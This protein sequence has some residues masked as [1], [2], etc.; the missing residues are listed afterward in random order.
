MSSST[1][2]HESSVFIG[3]QPCDRFAG[4]LGQTRYIRIRFDVFYW[5]WSCEALHSNADAVPWLFAFGLLGGCCFRPVGVGSQFCGRC[6]FTCGENAHATYRGDQRVRGR[7]VLFRRAESAWSVVT[8]ARVAAPARGYRR[9]IKNRTMRMTSTDIDHAAQTVA[10]VFCA[11]P[12]WQH[13]D[14]D[15]DKDNQQNGAL[16]THDSLLGGAFRRCCRP[17]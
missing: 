4:H 15:Q 13:A 6:G 9:P 7:A 14:E 12:C 3:P 16:S 11:G 10:P 17:D 8:G 1:Q 5:N 2:R